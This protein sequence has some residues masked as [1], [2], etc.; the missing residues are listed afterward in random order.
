MPNTNNDDDLSPKR[1]CHECVRESFLSAEIEQSAPEATCDYCGEP[2]ASLTIE[3]LADRIQ[4]AFE[5]HYN[6]TADQPDSW[7]ERM[8][9]DRESNYDWE[10]EGAP[11]VDAI[12]DAAMIPREAAEDVLAILEERHGDFGKGTMGEESEFSSDSYYEEKRPDDQ[13]WQ[14]EWRDFE[15]SLKTQA[16]FFSH[17]A[18]NHLAQVF[19]GIDKLKTRDTRPLVVGAA[20][21]TALDHLYRARVFQAEDKLEEALRRPDLHLGSPP[22]R[23]ARAGRMNAQ[24]ISVFYGA[25]DVSVA[26]TEVRPP[27]G[28]KVAVAKFSITRPLRLLDLTA[29]E[30][31]HDTGSIFDRSLKQRLERVA[32]LQTLSSR[33]ARPVMPDDEV[34]DYLPTQAVADF[35]ATMNEPRLDGIIF[36]SAQAQAG[37]NVVLFHHA[38]KVAESSFPKGTEIEASVGSWTEDGWE[39]EYAVLELVPPQPA[40]NQSAH[41]EVALGILSSHPAE[42]P[43]WSD[44]SREATLK[45]EPDTIEVH[46]VASVTVNSSPYAVHR[47]RHEKRKCKF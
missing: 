38:A 13:G 33:M 18:T 28:S 45:V 37:R 41:D 31:V 30:D 23:M 26:I 16:R 12:A 21:E 46:H 19:G 29:L 1:I 6:R 47:H 39:T 32:F 24:G 20:P 35:L 25:T 14:E 40:Q 2:L 17:T 7:Q 9:A 22:P 15:H 4:T 34:V 43:Y 44:D 42:S 8:L 3:D 11:V 27:V 10:R 5:E 36:S